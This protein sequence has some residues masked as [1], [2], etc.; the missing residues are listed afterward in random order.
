MKA[1]SSDVAGLVR[2]IRMSYKRRTNEDYNSTAV[3]QS[4]MRQ[5]GRPQHRWKDNIIIYRW[6][7]DK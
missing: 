5:L 7:L 3:A 1:V 2:L 6:I 4:E